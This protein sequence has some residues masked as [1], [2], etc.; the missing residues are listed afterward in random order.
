MA[1]VLLSP[2]IQITETDRSFVPARPLV[3]GAAIIGP[4][5]KGPANVPVVVTSYGEYQRLYGTTFMMNRYR[6]NYKEI[7]AE[8][9][10]KKEAETVPYTRDYVEATTITEEYV[11]EEGVQYYTRSGEDPDYTY[12]PYDGD[13]NPDDIYFV[14]NDNEEYVQI[15]KVLKGEK[16]VTYYVKNDDDTYSEAAELV[17]GTTYY[18]ANY[19]P[20]EKNDEGLYQFTLDE[21]GNIT[22][23]YYTRKEVEELDNESCETVVKESYNL[24]EGLSTPEA[25]RE[26]VEEQKEK[27]ADS[28]EVWEK[29][30]IQQKS[31]EYLTSIAAKSYFE[32]GGGSLLVVRVTDN[33]FSP[34]RAEVPTQNGKKAFEIRTISQGEYLNNWEGDP[35]DRTESTASIANVIRTDGSLISGSKNN[36]RWEIA[37]VDEET[38]TFTIYVRRGDDVDYDKNILEVFSGLNLDPDSEN[39]ISRRI[40]DQYQTLEEEVT[41]N[42][43]IYY[44]TVHGNYPNIS[45][46][47]YVVDV[48]DIY[49]YFLA[50]GYT[51]RGSKNDD[52]APSEGSGEKDDKGNCILD[53]PEDVANLLPKTCEGGFYDAQGKLFSSHEDEAEALFFEDI[54]NGHAGA[55]GGADKIQGINPAEYEK[56]IAVLENQDEYEINIISVPGL[57]TANN[58]A[59]VDMVASLAQKRGDLIAVVDLAG[60]GSKIGEV[61]ILAQGINSNYAATYWPWLQMYSSTGRLEWVPASVIVPGVYTFTDHVAAPWFAP[62]GMTRGSVQGVVQTERKLL[63]QNR[64]DLYKKNVNP[65]AILPGNGITIYGQKTLQKKAT[66]LDRVNV[67]RLMIELKRTVKNMASGILFEINDAQLRNTFKKNLDNYLESVIKRRGLYGYKTVVEEVNT[68]DVIDRNEFRCQIWVQPTK[69]IE[70]IYIDFTITNTGVD[71]S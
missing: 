63:K 59:Q 68:P 71:F 29:A 62:A 23:E 30:A 1:E 48:N 50:D 10:N 11:K 69:V 47:I 6:E 42:G 45:K 14:K 57:T 32:Q 40:G 2:G 8:E 33:D 9:L 56:L 20:V 25:Y 66:A 49:G 38:G 13:L 26:A 55:V 21:N 65:I 34:A 54:T 7:V 5:V 22:G 35:Q 43:S 31:Q 44:V 70:F 67:R 27:D 39:Y 17:S 24:L 19:T 37:D 61:Q 41:D 4:T 53:Y 28:D 60:F 51:R 16:G 52:T 18:E 58:A 12:E 15:E 46:Y 36:I 64:D 3:A